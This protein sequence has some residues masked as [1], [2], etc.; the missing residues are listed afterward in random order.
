MRNFKLRA[1][2]LVFLSVVLFASIGLSVGCRKDNQE[3]YTVTFEVDGGTA[4]SSKTVKKDAAI[5]ELPTTSKSGYG[6]FGWSDVKGGEVNVDENY[7]VTKNLTLYAVFKLGQ[8]DRCTI[9]YSTSGTAVANSTVG[10]GEAIGSLPFTDKRGYSFSGWFY[11]EELTQPVYSEDIVNGNITLYA[12]FEKQDVESVL[13]EYTELSLSCDNVYYDIEFRSDEQIDERNIDSFISVTSLYGE[14]PKI[15]VITQGDGEYALSPVGGYKNG[16]VYKIALTDERVSF[17][18]LD[19]VQGDDY[20]DSEA[21][22]TV[23]LSID[24]AD[25][26]IV[27]VKSDVLEL[28]RSLVVLDT[29]SDPMTFTAP[30]TVYDNLP[31]TDNSVVNLVG[32]DGDYYIK[33]TGVRRVDGNYEF[34][35][36]DCEDIDDVYD[37][38][39]LNVGDISVANEMTSP[40]NQAETDAMLAKVAAELYDSKGTQAITGMLAGALNASPTLKRMMRNPYRENVTD[41]KGYSFNIKGLM[42]DLEIKVTLGT[43]QNSSFDGIAISPFDNTPWTMLAISFNYETEIKNKVKLESTVTIKQYIFVGLAASANKSTGEFKAEVTPFSQTDIEFKIL[44]CSMSKDDEDDKD[45]DKDKKEEKKDISVEIEKLASGD[46]DSSNIIQ[47]VQEMLENKGDAIE[48]CKI[49][50]FTASYSVAGVISINFDLN[51]VV[52]VSFAA[53]VKIDATLLEATTIG[54]TGNYKT[55]KVDCYR[56]AAKGSDR[57]IFDFYAY[58]YLGLKAGIEG[59]LSVS[60]LG[61]NKLFR[62]G[63]SLE[64]GAYADLYGYLHYHAEETR[65]YKDVETN[66]R[67]FQTLEG[68]V[69]FESGIYIEIGA[70]VGV[71]KKE[72]GVSK[73]FKFKLLDAGDKYLYVEACENEDASIIFNENDENQISYED[74]IPAEG[75][76]LDITTG[77]VETRTI[78]AKNVKMISNTNLFKVDN[79]KNL[80]IANMDKIENRLNYG[81]P[82]GTISLYYKGPNILFSS[83]YLNENIP[84]LKGFKELCKVKVIYLASG[85]EL[86]GS[87]E[88]GKEVTITYNVQSENGT[89]TVKTE[90]VVSGQYYTGGIPFE[91]TSYCRQNGLLA[92]LDGETV[93]YSGYTSGKHIIT[94]DTTFVFTTAT[95]QRFIAVRYRSAEDFE[96]NPDMWTLDIMAM[97]YNEAATLLDEQKYTPQNVYYEYFVVTPDGDKTVMG[98]EYLSKYDL[99]MRGTHGYQTGV[100]L[101]TVY[102]TAKELDDLMTDMKNGGM[103]F[104]EYAEFFTFTLQAE[105][106]TGMHNVYFYDQFGDYSME[107]VKYG[108]SFVVPEYWIKNINQSA[109]K[110]LIGWDINGD[111]KADLM[112]NE[113]FVVTDDMVLLPVWGNVGYTITVEF[114]GGE[115]ESYACSANAKIAQ[116]VL[117]IINNAPEV[118]QAAP[119]G[120]Y[121]S[122]SYWTITP[123]DF[124]VGDEGYAY[125]R[126]VT[127]R[128]YGDITTMPACD[129]TIRCV[130]GELYHYVTLVDKTD[131]YYTYKNNAGETVTA[132]EVKIAVKDGG[133]ISAS[134]DY[135]Q[136]ELKYHAPEHVSYYSSMY[137]DANGDSLDLFSTKITESKTYNHTIWARYDGMYTITFDY[138]TF[139]QAEHKTERIRYAACITD[140]AQLAELLASYDADYDRYLSQ[141]YLDSLNNDEFV[142]SIY[143]PALNMKQSR[144]DDD[145]G[146]THIYYKVVIRKAYRMFTLTVDWG[147]ESGMANS[148]YT[149]KNGYL[150]MANTN[151]Y[152]TSAGEDEMY[153]Y[154][155]KYVVEGYDVDGDGVIDY[156]PGDLI[157]I[158]EDMTIKAVWK[159]DSRLTYTK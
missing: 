121:C 1:I 157:R 111:G 84:E 5:G 136:K 27:S 41:E 153:K 134:A 93:T 146:V 86:D 55:K 38:F 87:T 85:V 145:Y 132:D 144:F 21:I 158:T 68:G 56:R 9:I 154:E 58:G 30:K 7:I 127:Q 124:V 20:T 91:I 101:D 135:N 125:F 77:E 73:E 52:K 62:A 72:Y 120:S 108:E 115:T 40:E 103:R 76:F 99:Y 78:P 123:G 57:Y 80:L 147:E 31:F 100:V 6:F 118:P 116:N 44:V 36:V 126:G 110:R 114:Y 119:A 66:G 61:L 138:G 33:I 18:N 137:T 59:E 12:G 2:L 96:T 151:Y 3:N 150:F 26:K 143:D 71:G 32:K 75:K 67:H 90:K 117:D 142:Y 50:M 102:G 104:K 98:N 22:R 34:T 16:G 107:N 159:F 8:A 148:T 10:K 4:V 42:E 17:V 95:A 133:T 122:E 51:F 45:K 156:K 130:E 70:F 113:Q 37:D 155:D 112:P 82:Y 74:L 81:I 139:T 131:G 60:F 140:E 92:E 47:D 39:D 79:G 15:A 14:L 88:L 69:Y 28:D 152:Y 46:G 29:D 109:D 65:V 19:A 89:E 64:V 11:D 54:V 128:Y 13:P 94:E 129:I 141:E 43:A 24:A 83:A 25:Q 105:Y 149:L 35:Y 106:I 48:L 23:F 49:S 97:N 53:G 63:V